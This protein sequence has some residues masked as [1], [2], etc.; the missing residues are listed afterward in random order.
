MRKLRNLENRRRIVAVVVF[1]ITALLLEVFL[2]NYRHFE[3]L[4]FKE[5]NAFSFSSDI[6]DMTEGEN[7]NLYIL[8][9]EGKGTI[10]FSNIS[11]EIKNIY[12]K[13][14]SSTRD[15]VDF[16]VSYTDEGNEFLQETTVLRTVSSVERS[17][18]FRTHFSGLAESVAISFTMDPY[19]EI[20]ISAITLNS[21]VPFSFSF[22]RSELILAIFLICYCFSSNSSLWNMKLIEKE[23]RVVKIAVTCLLAVIFIVVFRKLT[24]LN[25][26]FVLAPREYDSQYQRLA[27]SFSEGK[28]YLKDTPPNWLINMKNPYDLSARMALEN[29][30]GEIALW[31][32]AYYNGRYYSYFGALPALIYYLPYFMITGSHAP[33]YFGIFLCLVVFTVFSIL[34][35][36]SIVKRWFKKTSFPLFL[37]VTT[38]FI[39]GSG[40][41]S[42]ARR[43][44]FYSFPIVLSLALTIGGLYFFISTRKEGKLSSV[45]L[46]LGSLL[47]SLNAL[48]RPQFLISA[49]LVIP[50]LWEDVFKNRILFSKKSSI[51]SLCFVLPIIIVAAVTMWY[52]WVRFS[53]PLDFGAN[54]NLTSNDM[55]VRGFVMARSWSG[56]FIYLLQPPVF[57]LVFPYL[58]PIGSSIEYIGKTISEPS[59]GGLFLTNMFS[60]WSLFVFRV[61]KLFSDKKILKYLSV[62]LFV[63]AIV[64]VIAD[65]QMAGI[66]PRYY[67]DFSWMILLVSVFVVLELFEKYEINDVITKILRTAIVITLFFVIGYQ[68]LLCYTDNIYSLRN[69]NPIKF[70]EMASLFSFLS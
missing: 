69:T 33:N 21:L 13:A 42:I 61:K 28:L 2:F 60:L 59:F 56:V 67:P 66:L 6:F 10:L 49:L 36:S 68:F 40:A 37:L 50:L 38:M 47:I 25:S 23:N 29:E 30:T 54:Y 57:D 9:D 48:S 19:D 39:A 51:Q 17:S 70:Q 52:N 18:Y 41:I 46:L 7:E 22:F 44:D 63:S 65:T 53:N 27:E 58:K 16:I 4:S 26:F 1:I 15:Y 32:H 34:L 5:L 55:T 14:E 11:K 43:P 20:T 35:I 64:V 62:L 31:D 3:S 24:T 45:R 8:S 12:I